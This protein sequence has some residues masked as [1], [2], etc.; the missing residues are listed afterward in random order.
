M[1]DKLQRLI[2]HARK[3]IKDLEIENDGQV[4][5]VF[6]GYFSSFG[7]SLVQAGLI[8]TV[9]FYE[10][11]GGAQGDR[12]KVCQAIYLLMQRQEKQKWDYTPKST[13]RKDY[14]LHPFLLEKQQ[15][16]GEEKMQEYLAH[17]TQYAIALKIALRTFN[18]NENDQ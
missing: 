3:A 1:K 7:A 6:R 9:I 2:P 8:P 17:I 4:P 16:E 5:S 15:T 11:E 12:Y 10:G 13:E 14:C 18:I